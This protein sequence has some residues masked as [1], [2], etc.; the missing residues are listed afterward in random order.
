ML[1]RRV[2]AA[3]A[4]L[5][6]LGC[7]QEQPRPSASPAPSATSE[8]PPAT[9]PPVTPSPSASPSATPSAPAS[10][11]ASP[12]APACSVVRGSR[13]LDDFQNA[14]VAFADA[15]VGVTAVGRKVFRTTNG[16][17]SWRAVRT[18]PG[19]AFDVVPA[20]CRTMFLL[21]DGSTGTHLDRSDDAGATWRRVVSNGTAFRALG[22]VTPRVGFAIE[23]FPDEPG[24][25]VWKTTDG[26]A[27]WRRIAR[28]PGDAV[29]TIAA[30]ANGVTLAGL[31]NG[32][33]RSTDGGATWT[34]AVTTPQRNWRT[35][36]WLGS[37]LSSGWA[38]LTGFDPANTAY[39]L[40]RTANL[41]GTWATVASSADRKLGS[42]P[43]AIG[44]Y[45]S[46]SLMVGRFDGDGVFMAR[47]TNG[48]T[49]FTRAP[50]VPL[51]EE[52]GDIVYGVSGIAW[53]TASNAVAVIGADSA[54]VY[55]TTNGGTTW[56]QV[57]FLEG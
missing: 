5:A 34:M 3:F 27:N 38:L 36:V 22:F 25:L 1:T 15:S 47:T 51:D 39:R 16:G 53:L 31:N 43:H 8:S 35:R 49:S 17:A 21:Y 33:A 29:F 54:G 30:A 24:G 7:S 20:G 32:V 37:N 57:A 19:V 10:P 50:L 44:G 23:S 13:A 45:G 11:T 46:A 12:T 2:A 26:G 42:R 52:G 55:R 6:L 28:Q 40:H 4:A 14:S 41:A 48:G 18:L 56:R 9:A